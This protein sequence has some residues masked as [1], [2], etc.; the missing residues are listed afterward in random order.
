MKCGLLDIFT[1]PSKSRVEAGVGKQ[2]DFLDFP[3]PTM[4]GKAMGY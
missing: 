3:T 1:T 4:S 2:D